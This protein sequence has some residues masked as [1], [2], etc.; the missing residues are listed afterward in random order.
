MKRAD[1]AF[2]ATR[3]AHHSAPHFSSP[4]LPGSPDA[5]QLRILIPKNH[6]ARA[7]G[8]PTKEDLPSTTEDSR[9]AQTALFPAIRRGTQA[10]GPSGSPKSPNKQRPIAQPRTS[11]IKSALILLLHILL[12]F[13]SPPSRSSS[14]QT[15][16]R[17]TRPGRSPTASPAA[18]TF[19]PCNFCSEDRGRDRRVQDRLSST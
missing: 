1:E 11:G 10:H 5:L 19:R 7:P 13:P 3:V 17:R 9:A 4:P 12:L 2:R 14:G 18:L 16:P 15:Q 8:L 6:R